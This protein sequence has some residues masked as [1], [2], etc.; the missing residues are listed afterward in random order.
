LEFLSKSNAVRAVP[1]NSFKNE[2]MAIKH[3][4]HFIGIGGIGMSGLAELLVRQGCRVSGS[5]LAAG[6]ITRR[7]EDLGV[8]FHQGHRAGNLEEAQVVVHTAAV[9]EDNPELAAARPGASPS[10]AGG[11]CWPT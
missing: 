6:P 1:T 5:D 8:T 3:T 2:I 11:K 9:K 7:L 10:C 4:Y